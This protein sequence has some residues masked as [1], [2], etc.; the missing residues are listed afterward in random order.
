MKKNEKGEYHRFGIILK[1]IEGE[2]HGFYIIFRMIEGEY[3]G[4]YIILRMIDGKYQ[5]LCIILKF[6]EGEYGCIFRIIYSLRPILLVLY[7]KSNLLRE[8]HFWWE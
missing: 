1:M 8:H 5:G 2:Y 7:R 6:D 3:H 4:F